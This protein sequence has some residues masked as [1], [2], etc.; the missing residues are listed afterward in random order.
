MH[1]LT[2]LRITT[3]IAPNSSYWKSFMFSGRASKRQLAKILTYAIHK[4]GQPIQHNGN[5]IWRAH[6]KFISFDS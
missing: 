2:G 6:K 3:N 4:Y 1:K 5:F